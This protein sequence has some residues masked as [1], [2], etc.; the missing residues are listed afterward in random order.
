VQAKKQMVGEDMMLA[1]T[2]RISFK[3][4][5]NEGLRGYLIVIAQGYLG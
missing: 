2:A 4:T 1:M 3:M 5:I